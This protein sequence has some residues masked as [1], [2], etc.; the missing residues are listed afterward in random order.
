M[1]KSAYSVSKYALAAIVAV[2][3]TAASGRVSAGQITG[4]GVV[5]LPP[6]MVSGSAGFTASGTLEDPTGETSE[7]TGETKNATFSAPGSTSFDVA[8]QTNCQ[9]SV[10]GFNWI[11]TGSSATG[12]VDISNLPNPS[13][14]ATA[15]LLVG[16]ANGTDANA[17]VSAETDYYFEIVGGGPNT[18]SPVQILVNAAGGYT[19]ALNTPGYEEF[20]TSG[21]NSSFFLAGVVTN[22]IV[23]SSEEDIG[24]FGP[25]S[26]SWSNT[27]TYMLTTNEV[28]EVRLAVSLNLSLLGN[29]GGGGQTMSAYVDPTFQ[30]A[31]SADASTYSLVFSEGIGNSPGGAV[32]EPSTWAMML[33]GFAG[34][35]F[36][37]YRKAKRPSLSVA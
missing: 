32:P 1:T 27:N 4:P 13:I 37:A 8:A 20:L 24:G 29:E 9:C 7:Q 19:Y 3:L 12:S 18:Q 5:T 31:D 36:V 17:F 23:R 2:M 22:Q 6:A 30:F 34:M 21:V 26:E 10:P 33:L 35:G 28:Y 14:R 15:S 11:Q 16:A 25:G